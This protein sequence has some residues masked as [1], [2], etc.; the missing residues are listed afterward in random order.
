MCAVTE[1][2]LIPMVVLRLEHLNMGLNLVLPVEVNGIW[3]VVTPYDTHVLSLFF[4][5]LDTREIS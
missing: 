3:I 1:G 2:M 5:P 4:L